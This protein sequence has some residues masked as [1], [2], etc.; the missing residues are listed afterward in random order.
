VRAI[1]PGQRWT[2]RH[3]G[4]HVVVRSCVSYPAGEVVTLDNG[5]WLSADS[6]RYSYRLAHC[7]AESACDTF[8]AAFVAIST[9][10]T[11]ILALADPPDEEG[12]MLLSGC[13][14]VHTRSELLDAL[15]VRR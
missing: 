15:G 8:H 3:C 9:A 7:P 4:T 2:G 5:H 1:L 11:I 12:C 10:V 13:R 6:L 14:R